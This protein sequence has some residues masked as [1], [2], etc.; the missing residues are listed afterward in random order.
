MQELVA[1]LVTKSVVDLLKAVEV[2]KVQ[3]ERLALLAHLRGELR[4][5]S[6]VVEARQL[7]GH[8]LGLKLDR[9]RDVLRK[10]KD[11]TDGSVLEPAH[12]YGVHPQVL[13]PLAPARLACL[14]LKGHIA[15][16][17]SQDALQAARRQQRLDRLAVLGP[18]QR[19]PAIYETYKVTIDARLGV[20]RRI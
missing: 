16:L 20:Q 14:V 18:V 9:G 12:G 17:V 7:V 19:I 3:R 4:E 11:A 5:A 13:D 1:R 8:G 2:K 6:F 15:G 10:E